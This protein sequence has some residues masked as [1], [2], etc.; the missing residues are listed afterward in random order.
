MRYAPTP[1]E[2]ERMSL[3]V[4]RAAVNLIREE[5][6]AIQARRARLAAARA[7]AA[8]VGEAT[9]ADVRVQAHALVPAVIELHG[10]TPDLQA[11]RCRA[12]DADTRAYHRSR[13]RTAA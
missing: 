3:L 1:A 12:L 4:R 8:T 10:D 9:A 13:R 11:A 6:A 5:A 7:A 2:Y